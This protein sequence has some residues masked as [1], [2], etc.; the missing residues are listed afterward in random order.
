MQVLQGIQNYECMIGHSFF[1]IGV[2]QQK[3]LTKKTPPISQC[4]R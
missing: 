1:T 4:E 3:K 2:L